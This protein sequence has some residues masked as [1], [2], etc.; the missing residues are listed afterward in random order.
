MKEKLDTQAVL[1]ILKDDQDESAYNLLLEKH[2][3]AEKLF[4]KHAKALAK[5][6]TEVKKDFPDAEFYT[7]SGGFNLLLGESHTNLGG[8][9]SNSNRNLSALSS[10]DLQ[11]GDGD[12]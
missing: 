2:P 4:D 9:R 10:F 12:W 3:N 6:L 11:V 5:L 8:G 1:E 7:A